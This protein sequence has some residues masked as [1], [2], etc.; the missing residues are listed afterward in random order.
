M[1]LVLEIEARDEVGPA[2]DVVWVKKTKRI[3]IQ[4]LE[5]TQSGTTALLSIQLDGPD[6]S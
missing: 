3:V 5:R 4:G 1:H 2:D 6:R